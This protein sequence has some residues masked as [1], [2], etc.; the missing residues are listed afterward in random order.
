M[1]MISVREIEDMPND[2]CTFGEKSNEWIEL[3]ERL[4]W[5]I[6][7]TMYAVI[8]L[9]KIPVRTDLGSLTHKAEKE[10]IRQG[11]C[12]RELGKFVSAVLPEKIQPKDAL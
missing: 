2:F 4:P 10:T 1:F 11:A 12:K 5:D 3:A 6:C 8:F 7:E 9:S